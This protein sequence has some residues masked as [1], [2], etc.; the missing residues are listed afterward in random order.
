[1][2]ATGRKSGNRILVQNEHINFFNEKSMV[3][4][5]ERLDSKIKLEVN[6][7]TSPDGN[8]VKVIQCLLSIEN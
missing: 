1:M 6:E 8:I 2:P 5:S 3:V 4:L 7:I